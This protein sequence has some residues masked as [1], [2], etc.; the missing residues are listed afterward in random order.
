MYGT[1]GEI[2]FSDTQVGALRMTIASLVLLPFALRSIRK[3]N[4]VR[5]LLMLLL[6][7]FCGNFF[8]AFLFTFSETGISSGFAGMLNSFT[9]IFALIIGVVIFKQRMTAIQS[10]GVLVGTTGVTLLMLAG[11]DISLMGSWYH[12]LAV[13][14]ATFCYAISLNT[15]KYTLDGFRSFDITALAFGVIFIPSILL[16]VSTGSFETIAEHPHSLNGLFYL[17]ILSVVGTAFAVALF[18]KLV[19]MSSVIFA[20]SVTYLIPIVA[21]MIGLYFGEK[22]SI[23]QVLSMLL[24]LGGVFI[25]NAKFSFSLK[26]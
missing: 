25:A 7:G 24:V 16:A 19:A 17:G 2:I 26:K 10:I 4:S 11:K 18:T 12:I 21:V 8:P 22:I 1:E 9:P 6:V 13:V 3:I 15:I 23:G 5:Q 14:L 20:S